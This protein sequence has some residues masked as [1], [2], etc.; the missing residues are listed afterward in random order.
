MDF[1]QQFKTV[2]SKKNIILKDAASILG[3]TRPHL[4]N[5]IHGNTQPG[6]TLAVAIYN[7]CDKEIDFETILLPD[8][9]K[10]KSST[11]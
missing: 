9:D 7:F 2:C 3:V 10:W 1:S 8:N 11:T 6:T 5:V 4:S